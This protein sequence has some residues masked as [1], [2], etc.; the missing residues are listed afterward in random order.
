M[1]SMSLKMVALHM[2][3]VGSGLLASPMARAQAYE[4][5][6]TW[7]AAWALPVKWRMNMAI[8]G[9][10]GDIVVW[11]RVARTSMGAAG[12]YQDEVTVCGLAQPGTKTLGLFGGE[13]FGVAYDGDVLGQAPM[14]RPCS[15]LTAFGDGPDVLLQSTPLAVQVGIAMPEPLHTP[16]PKGVAA[17]APWL[18]RMSD[19][20]Q[21]GAPAQS[22]QDEGLVWP[23][24][25]Y[26]GQRRAHHFYIASRT[27]LRHEGRFVSP[28]RIEGVAALA[29]VQGRTGL[30]TTIVGCDTADGGH[31]SEGDLTLTNSFQPGMRANGAGR[32]VFVRLPDGASCAQVRE[33]LPTAP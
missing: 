7:A 14:P 2:A 31:C 28:D 19:N 6:G 21:L 12:R 13:R 26:A 30:N 15:Q 1:K 27:V 8:E 4:P 11:A 10:S 18:L 16:W 29:D 22:R 25:D 23:P 9:N 3:L 32:A 20:G 5:T 24:I 17:L 33:A